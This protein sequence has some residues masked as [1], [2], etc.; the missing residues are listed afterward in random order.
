MTF[1]FY[2]VCPK[3]DTAS[4]LKEGLLRSKSSLWNASGGAIYLTKEKVWL[5]DDKTKDTLKITLNNHWV[6]KMKYGILNDYGK[7]EEWQFVC[8]SD[9]PPKYIKL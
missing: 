3:E 6:A 7:G 2:H 8:W 1:I 5:Q 9:I 4:I